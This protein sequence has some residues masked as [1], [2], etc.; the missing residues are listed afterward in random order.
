MVGAGSSRAHLL[1]PLVSLYWIALSSPCIV[2]HNASHGLNS[3]PRAAH[4]A[5]RR[6]ASRSTG[7]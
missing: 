4:P 5:D 3:R 6:A 7:H 2:H 1:M